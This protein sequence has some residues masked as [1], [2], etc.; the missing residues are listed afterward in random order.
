[1]SEPTCAQDVTPNLEGDDRVGTVFWCTQS[2]L[3]VIFPGRAPLNVSRETSL[4][5][6]KNQAHDDRLRIKVPSGAQPNARCTCNLFRRR[7]RTEAEMCRLR[8][9]ADCPSAR[10]AK[11][12]KSDYGIFMIRHHSNGSVN[13]LSRNSAS[14]CCFNV[15]G[16]AID[17]LEVPESAFGPSVVL[18]SGPEET[19]GLRRNFAKTRCARMHLMDG[20]TKRFD[21]GVPPRLNS[22]KWSTHT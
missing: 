11:L 20:S 12:K 6:R 16:C 22:E 8:G 21:E 3:F 5:Y 7:D 9:A 15:H 18:D 13:G 14:C 4:P 17:S 2:I 10:A 19:D 1:V